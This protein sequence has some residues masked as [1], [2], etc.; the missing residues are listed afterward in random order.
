VAYNLYR[1]STDGRRGG[2]A[3][4]TMVSLSHSGTASYLCFADS[5]I[6]VR[7]RDMYRRRKTPHSRKVLWTSGLEC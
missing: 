7:E 6:L 5:A 3:V 4:V 2:G 1:L